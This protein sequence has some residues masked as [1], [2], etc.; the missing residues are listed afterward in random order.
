MI[1]EMK[2]RMLVNLKGTQQWAVVLE[3][4]ADAGDTCRS[5]LIRIQPRPSPLR[6]I[7][8]HHGVH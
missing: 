6:C 7:R 4:Q 2:V 3:E 1:V 8:C 5:W